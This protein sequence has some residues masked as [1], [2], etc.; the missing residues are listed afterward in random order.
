[1]QAIETN[2][3]LVKFIVAAVLFFAWG[4]VQGA[5]QAQGPIHEFI[6][7]GPAAI[8]VGA[9]VHVNLLGWVSLL[10]AAVVYYLVPVLSGKPIAA[11]R[12]INWIF[13]VFVI[14]FT[15]QAVL[16]ITVG[17]RAGNA[18]IAGVVGPQLE[19]LMTPYMM[20]IGILSIICGIVWLMFV[21]QILV[22][23]G[24]KS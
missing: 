22:T 18:F 14:G 20:P 3:R 23:V 2:K 1:M 17:I 10:L 24:R 5:L 15:I 21:V 8:I 4:V 6:T 11:P 12:L 16:M 19:A 9:H 7:Q 13:W